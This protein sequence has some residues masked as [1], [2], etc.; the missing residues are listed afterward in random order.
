MT[1]WSRITAGLTTSGSA[2]LTTSMSAGGT[3]AS[4]ASCAAVLLGCESSGEWTEGC[5]TFGSWDMVNGLGLAGVE[6][7]GHRRLNM[8]DRHLVLSLNIVWGLDI[9]IVQP[10]AWPEGKADPQPWSVVSHWGR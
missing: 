5:V 9:L 10:D 3:P 8:I 6:S 4:L 7:R 1:Y 2:G